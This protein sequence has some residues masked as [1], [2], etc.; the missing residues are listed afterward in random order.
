MAGKAKGQ[1]PQRVTQ[2]PIRLEKALDPRE[3]QMY[4]KHLKQR[5]IQTIS[6]SVLMRLLIEKGV[7]SPLD[8]QQ[9]FLDD[10]ERK[11]L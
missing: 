6:L 1:A 9:G 5:D 2:S 11:G 7:L 3:F 10:M 8:V 4:I